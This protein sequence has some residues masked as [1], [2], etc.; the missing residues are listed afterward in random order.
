MSSYLPMYD[1]VGY[2]TS[3][4]QAT[5]GPDGTQKDEKYTKLLQIETNESS[6]YQQP[7]HSY[8]RSGTK[9]QLKLKTCLVVM[10]LIVVFL[11]IVITVGSVLTSTIWR[12]FSY[13]PE[14]CKMDT[15]TCTSLPNNQ[16][17]RTTSLPI[18]KLVSGNK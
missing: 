1:T 14:N 13:S 15:I 8:N 3:A 2:M 4:D 7:D 5:F 16:S 12:K 10:S 6:V 18:Y 9:S 11:L 17:C